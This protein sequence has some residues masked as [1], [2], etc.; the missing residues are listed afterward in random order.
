V[1]R[2]LLFSIAFLLLV[3]AW[4]TGCGAEPTAIVPPD[5][6][7]TVQ[8]QS[9]ETRVVQETLAGGTDVPTP[10]AKSH[11]EE[12]TMMPA[13][14]P[15]ATE[16]EPP[17]EAEQVIQLAQ[18][19]LAQRL[20]L[21]PEAIRLVSV[22]AVEWSDTSLGCPQPGMTISAQVIPGFRVVLT[23]S[24]KSYEYHSDTKQRV[25]CCEP[26]RAQP[27]L[28]GGSTETVKLAKEDLARR[29]G[30]SID[31]IDVVAVIRQEFPVD[32]FY[33]RTTKER[34][35]RDESPAVVSGESILLSAAGRRYEYHASDQTVIFCRQLR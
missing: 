20:G 10:T 34:I 23:A 3:G 35:A 32:A 13:S 5:E 11:R 22:E 4:A 27:V 7:I 31:S 30:I 12:A 24:G 16:V 8:V 25:I 2:H 18:E 26:Q 19:D 6:P 21:A 33:C 9:V 14:P 29:L 1:K 15:E 17:A 28:N